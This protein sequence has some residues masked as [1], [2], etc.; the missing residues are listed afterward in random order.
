MRL[1]QAHNGQYARRALSIEKRIAAQE[2][3]TTDD[4]GGYLDIGPVMSPDEW[5][6]AAREQ[7]A[8]LIRGSV[9]GNTQPAQ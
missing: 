9:K 6:Q 3:A 7:K 2:V 4:K 8:A 1:C 5:L